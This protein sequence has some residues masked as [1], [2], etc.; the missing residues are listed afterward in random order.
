MKIAG[1]KVYQV[2]LPLHEGKYSWSEGY[3]RFHMKVGGIL[4][5]DIERIR[6]VREV[7]QLADNLIADGAPQGVNVRMAASTEAGLGINPKFDVL[8]D[9]VWSC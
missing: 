1:L 7:L 4:E 2:D 6:P 3:R 9:P 8:G 5:D